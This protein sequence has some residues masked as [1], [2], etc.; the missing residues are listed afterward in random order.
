VPVA[1]ARRGTLISVRDLLDTFRLENS[2][3]VAAVPIARK[4]DLAENAS[5]SLWSIK[6]W[7]ISPTPRKNKD[8]DDDAGSHSGGKDAVVEEKRITRSYR[9]DILRTRGRK[10]VS[11]EMTRG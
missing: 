3:T 8:I 2:L 11:L 5:R 7:R 1:S 4:R 9:N 10:I 6:G